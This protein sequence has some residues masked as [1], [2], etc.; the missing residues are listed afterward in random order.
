MAYLSVAGHAVARNCLK[1]GA[2]SLHL[3][4]FVGVLTSHPR[5]CKEGFSFFFKFQIFPLAGVGIIGGCGVDHWE[6]GEVNNK[7]EVGAYV[8]KLQLNVRSE[9]PPL[10]PP[11]P[12]PTCRGC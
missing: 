1:G 9:I 2:W 6:E 12:V 4:P 10:P 3:N 8:A 7:H 5:I 11:P